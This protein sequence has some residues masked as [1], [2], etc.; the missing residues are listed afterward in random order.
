[1]DEIERGNAVVIAGDSFAADDAR[2]RVQ[3]G[4]RLNDERESA[5]E[6]VAGTAVKAHSRAVLRGNNPKAIVLDL[7]PPDGNLSV[8]VGRH[9]AMNPAGRVRCNIMPIAKD[10]SRVSQP[11]SEP[12]ID[13]LVMAIT[14][15]EA[16]VRH[17]SPYQ[18]AWRTQMRTNTTR[19]STA[20]LF[21]V[22]VAL[23]ATSFGIVLFPH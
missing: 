5:G 16:I 18:T 3:A 9:G 12:Q 8:F 20:R 22:A 11:F 6:V 13:H 21:A 17:T 19:T 1:M 7:V 2:A 10:F 14:A 15:A 23:I 4:Q